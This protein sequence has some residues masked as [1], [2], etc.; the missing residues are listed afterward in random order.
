MKVKPYNNIV[1]AE[2][3]KDVEKEGN[4]V[5][6]GGIYLPDEHVGRF[7]QIKILEVG[8]LVEHI[9]EGDLCYANP[10]L[11]VIDPKKPKIGFINSKDILAKI[12]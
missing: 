11:E 1:L 8:N 2:I 6:T 5:S 7:I 10:M 3:V 12:E 4:Q 9:K